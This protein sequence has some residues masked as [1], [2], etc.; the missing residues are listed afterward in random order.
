MQRELWG[1]EFLSGSGDRFLRSA[2]FGDSGRTKVAGNCAQ[3]AA[4]AGDC[5]L[6]KGDRW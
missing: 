6:V 4:F 1:H 2:G 5:F 3:V